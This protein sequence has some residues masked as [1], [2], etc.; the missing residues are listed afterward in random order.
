[1]L[2]GTL[3]LA[4]ALALSAPG[5]FAKGGDSGGGGKRDVR[6]SPAPSAPVAV[7]MPNAAPAPDILLRESFG[8]GSTVRPNGGKGKLKEI[9]SHTS[10][11]GFW[12]EYPASKNTAWLAPAEGQTWKICQATPDPYE[13]PSPL[14]ASYANGCITSGLF[15]PDPTRPTALMPFRAPANA[16]EASFDGHPFVGVGED[17]GYLALGF[18]DSALLE[19][20]LQTSAAVWLVLRPGSSPQSTMYYELRT[21]GVTG[22]VLA[23]GE[24]AMEWYSRIALR[25]DPLAQTVSAS[26]NGIELGIHRH[27]IAPPRFIGIEGVGFV[28]NF[29]VRN[30]R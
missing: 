26:V 7:P 8:L 5:A 21:D 11:A 28:D 10:L 1:M 6:A 12:I 13:M 4:V 14:Q 24:T 22:P 3:S 30:V 19:S 16:Y 17:G 25:Y 2:A 15:D 29:I 23:S 9:F 20:N 18:T 27:A